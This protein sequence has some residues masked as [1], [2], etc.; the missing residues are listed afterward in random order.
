VFFWCFS[1]GVGGCGLSDMADS[2]EQKINPLM[3]FFC[4]IV[5]VVVVGGYCI[6]IV[7]LSGVH[8]LMDNFAGLNLA[9]HIIKEKLPGHLAEYYG[10]D[11]SM[12]QSKLEALAF[13][14]ETFDPYSCTI[15]GIPVG[16]RLV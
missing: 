2:E 3:S 1:F 13:D 11:A 9:L 14:W 12:V 8:Y 6:C 5:V 15:A 4:V 10:Y 7:K 16:E